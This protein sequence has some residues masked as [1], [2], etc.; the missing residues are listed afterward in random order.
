[1][2]DPAP[3]LAMKGTTKHFGAVEAPV[4]VDFEV[5]AGEVVARG[6]NGAGKPTL[7]KAVFGIAIVYQDIARRDHLDLVANL[8]LG[9]ERVERG[10]GR[11]TRALDE[12]AMEHEALELLEAVGVVQTRQV[13]D[14]I[15]HLKDRGRGVVIIS[16]NLDNGFHAADRIVVLRLGRRVA[17]F[18][19]RSTSRTE[20]VAAIT[21]AAAAPE[22]S[23]A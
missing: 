10:V 22:R 15:G 4:D 23:A 11:A 18:D 14:L 5:Y 13:L 1:M 6:D 12:P 8:F 2:D 21:S 16:Y 3:L 20:V 19:R 9:G 17:S 7:I